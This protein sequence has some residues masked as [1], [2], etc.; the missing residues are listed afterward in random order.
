MGNI[1]TYGA[2]T[3][4]VEDRQKIYDAYKNESGVPDFEWIASDIQ[5]HNEANASV[6]DLLSFYIENKREIPSFLL[7]DPNV[8][9][10]A[11]GA[12]LAE[13]YNDAEFVDT[14][15]QWRANL[16]A[17]LQTYQ[18]LATQ[19]Q[20]FLTHTNADTS[21][22]TDITNFISD[23]YATNDSLANGD[24]PRGE[25][26]NDPGVIMTNMMDIA[27][28]LGNPG[29]ALL[30]YTMGNQTEIEV[31]D[32]DRFLDPNDNVVEAEAAP[33]EKKKVITK[34]VGLGEV[35]M[36]FQGEVVS[37]LEDLYGEIE[38]MT[39]EVG[40]LDPSDSD[41]QAR[42]EELRTRISTSQSM[43]R[44]HTELLE[45]AQNLVDAILEAASALIERQNRASG[46][47]IQRI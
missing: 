33:G 45:M 21:L 28:K 38:D 27:L 30:I 2:S 12:E 15:N 14:A 42:L 47:I 20:E 9:D 29:L 40:S 32:G 34:N 31:E 8:T 22:T 26:S 11:L 7:S 46:S 13:L 6:E 1:T 37:E 25:G 10:A 43:A 35:V 17:D 44:T 24:A 23:W 16:Q 19:L 41:D 4:S 3:Y 18:G 5:H 36:D 39:E